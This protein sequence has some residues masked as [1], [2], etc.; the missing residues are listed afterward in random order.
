[1]EMQGNNTR[2]WII[3]AVI[4]LLLLLS[5]F[6]FISR[7][8]I[9]EKLKK[10]KISS[11][12]LLSEKLA[13]NKEVDQM[14]NDMKSLTSKFQSVSKDLEAAREDI[15]GKDKR[16]GSL[17]RELSSQKKAKTELAEL[18]KSKEKLDAEM[19]DLRGKYE[20]LKNEN[21]ATLKDLAEMK[22]KGDEL[23]AKI[24][25]MTL[26]DADDFMVTPLKRLNKER[27][28]ICSARTK[29]LAVRFEVPSSLTGTISFSV[30]APDG[31]V[32]EGSDK[33][34]AWMVVEDGR[35]ITA[36]LS[37]VSREFENSKQV[38]LIYTAKE[39][40]MPGI[41][42]IKVTSGQNTLGNCRVKLK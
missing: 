6:S 1:M 9:N 37:P 22:K 3:G 38:E 39:R 28:T 42:T 24:E 36:S 15:T 21:E 18:Q 11:E 27:L 35:D 10:E 4:V 5:A 14:S 30:I 31:K 20:K 33:A 23:L 32:I 25:E 7:H 12:Q 19:A 8:S 29:R 2:N 17:L 13:L 41:Y 26:Y 40:L 34:L 16:I